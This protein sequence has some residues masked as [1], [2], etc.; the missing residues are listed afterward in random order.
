VR[1]VV[2]E[3]RGEKVDI[4]EWRDDTR[5]F[6]SEALSPARVKEVRLD[7]EERIAAVVVPDHQLSLAIGKEGQ[8]ARLAARLTGYKIDIRSE[9]QDLGLE[10][11]EETGL[12][13]TEEAP[14]AEQA[15]AAASA[16]TVE[17][18]EAAEVAEDDA[19]V[20]DEPDVVE[21]SDEAVATADEVVS[22]EEPVAEETED[23]PTVS[24]EVVPDTEEQL[25]EDDDE[26]DAL[27]G[28]QDPAV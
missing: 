13:V 24:S 7:E 27:A 12:P 16:E 26:V 9:S 3:L 6:I 23:E 28:D 18:V 1:Q 19:D 15:E 21:S 14:P 22:D 10:I 25:Q 5:A 8:N 2:N 4:V 11:D 20:E 17:S